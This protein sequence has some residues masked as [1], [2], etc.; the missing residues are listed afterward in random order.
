MRTSISQVG[1]VI[2]ISDLQTG[3]FI[4]GDDVISSELF[5]ECADGQLD[6]ELSPHNLHFAQFVVAPKHQY[7]T[8]RQIDNLLNRRRASA[9][10]AVSTDETETV[11]GKVAQLELLRKRL[12]PGDPLL[13]EINHLCVAYENE[14]KSNEMEFNRSLGHPVAYGAVIQ[15]KH[16]RSGKFLSQSRARARVDPQAMALRLLAGG[17]K[18]SWLRIQ[19]ADRNRAEGEH[20]RIGDQVYMNA[21]KFPGTFITVF[22]SEE[23]GPRERGASDA[24]LERGPRE[25]RPSDIGLTRKNVAVHSNGETQGEQAHRANEKTRHTDVKDD[26][27]PALRLSDTPPVSTGKNTSTTSTSRAL[28]REGAVSSSGSFNNR[29]RESMRAPRPP[30]VTGDGSQNEDGC[31]DLCSRRLEVNAASQHHDLQIKLIRTWKTHG[32]WLQAAVSDDN[33]DQ[34]PVHG[35]DVVTLK[36]G[37]DRLLY[38]E[39]SRQS[40]WWLLTSDESV[41]VDE[42]AMLAN[43]LWRLKPVLATLAGEVFTYG[44]HSDFYLE[45]VVSGKY[46]GQSTGCKVML[47]EPPERGGTTGAADGTGGEYAIKF[48]ISGPYSEEGELSDGDTL[49]MQI[50]SD[51]KA[52]LHSHVHSHGNSAQTISAKTHLSWLGVSKKKPHPTRLHAAL[53]KVVAGYKERRKAAGVATSPQPEGAKAAA[54]DLPAVS[55][56]LKSQDPRASPPPNRMASSFQATSNGGSNP[57]AAAGG[58]RGGWGGVEG[59]AGSRGGEGGGKGE[60]NVQRVFLPVVIKKGTVREEFDRLEI[61]LEPS[62]CMS[63]HH[64]HLSHHHTHMS[65]HHTHMMSLTALRFRW[66][67]V[68]VCV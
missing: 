68:C 61:S 28:A 2:G 60:G 13:E 59:G 4:A 67:Q 35:M 10:I 36:H 1:D 57:N 51:D 44:A 12:A 40:I 26:Q 11:G 58:R 53:S 16:L 23:R 29:E 21:A 7:S 52:S 54:R 30:S 5:L 31:A 46:L 49:W 19:S 55:P 37:S 15:L 42:H 56:L 33:I 47:V 43:S 34:N 65:H 8:H 45:H 18:G 39:P 3:G 41:K 32:Q 9:G 14:A 63:H 27:V 64:T 66:S 20:V 48:F 17:N 38:A 6:S 62:M 24:G 50:R 22:E 25:R